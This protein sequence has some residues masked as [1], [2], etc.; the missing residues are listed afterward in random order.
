MSVGT[1]LQQISDEQLERFGSVIYA[2]AGIKVSPQKKMMLSNRLRRRLKATGLDS[3][4]AY[5]DLL[6]R[7]PADDPEWDAFL[8]EVSTHETFLFRDENHWKWFQTEFL[9]AIVSQAHSGERSKSLRVWSAACSTGDEAYTIATCIVATVPDYANWKI[10][11]VGTDIGV[12]A[13]EQAQQAVF[14]ERS[15]KLV[16][17]SLRNKLF[18]PVAGTTCWKAKPSLSQWMSFRQHNLLEPLKEKP[19][20]LIFVKNVLI[21]FDT[22]SKKRALAN[23]APLLAPGGVL[24]TAAAEGVA[25][26]LHDLTK[27]KPWLYRR[28]GAKAKP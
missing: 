8:Q 19:F 2:T 27:E 1:Q 3:F 21:Y 13:V 7:R 24:V 23:I 16:P 18:E 17:E 4:D 6:K 26:L 10:S 11:I 28:P 25:G 12:G 20:D 9:P 15:M 5:L 22:A 14:N